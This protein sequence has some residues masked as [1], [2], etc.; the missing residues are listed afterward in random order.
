M[1]ALGELKGLTALD[2]AD[3]PVED[4]W[5]PELYALK[6]KSINLDG[7]LFTAAGRDAL[8]E[9]LGTDCTIKGTPKD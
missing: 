1:R 5:L 9:K 3:H 2:L 7:T 4:G 6:L 8:Q